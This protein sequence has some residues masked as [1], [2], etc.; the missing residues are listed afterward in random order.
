MFMNP[1]ISEIAIDCVINRTLIPKLTNIKVSNK[2]PSKYLT[3]VIAKNKD[4]TKA[5]RSHMLNTDLLTGDYDKMYDYFLAERAGTIF[6]AIDENV[7]VMRTSIL[8]QFAMS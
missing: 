4:I 7:T 5:L 6:A 8:N 3:E 2:P 1:L